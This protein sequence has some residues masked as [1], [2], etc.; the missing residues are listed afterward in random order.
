MKRLALLLAASVVLLASCENPAQ[1]VP[2]LGLAAVF[3]VF[4]NDTIDIGHTTKQLSFRASD[5]I[6][7]RW[8]VEVNI[9][10]GGK[11]QK[12]AVEIALTKAKA[13]LP[14]DWL[15]MEPI[16]NSDCSAFK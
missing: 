5:G 8:C 16:Y 10:K 14:D 13:I 4:P 6:F 2:F 9:D 11:K 3:D 12:A 1:R 7:D 15:V